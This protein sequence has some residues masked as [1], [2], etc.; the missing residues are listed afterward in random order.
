MSSTPVFFNAF[1]TT[2]LSTELASWGYNP[3]GLPAFA[4]AASNK[5]FVGFEGWVLRLTPEEYDRIYDKLS[6]A[7]A[8]CCG[9]GAVSE[10]REGRYILVEGIPC[11]CH[12]EW[13]WSL[14][15]LV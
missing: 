8:A 5:V 14:E 15:V 1:L 4:V 7:C 9:F 13:S 6:W 3:K 11:S 10:S 2:K 12:T